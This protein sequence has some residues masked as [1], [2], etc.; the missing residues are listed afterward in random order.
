EGVLILPAPS[1]R[2]GGIRM[3][4]SACVRLLLVLALW[5]VPAQPQLLKL[6]SAD[7][8]KGDTG[9]VPHWDP[10]Q[11]RLLA[12]RDTSDSALATA[13]VFDSSGNS[14]PLFL[15][16][17][18]P[19]AKSLHVWAAAASPDG[20][21]ILSVLQRVSKIPPQR[22][23]EASEVEE[24]VVGGD[25]MLMTN[26]QSA[27]L[28]EPGVGS[29]HDPSPPVATKFTSVFVSPFL[30]VA[31]VRCDQFNAALAQSLAQ[32]IGI[33]SAVGNHA[34]RPWR[35][36]PFGRGTRTFASVSSASVTS[37]GEA[38]S[39][40]TPSGTPSP[41]ASTIHFVPLPRLVLPTASPLFSPGQNCRRERSRPIAAIP[42]GP[43]RPAKPATHPAIRL[44]LATVA[45]AASRS[46]AKETRRAETATP[47]R[48]AKPTECLQNRPGSRLAAVHACPFAV[49]A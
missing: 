17:D 8:R 24:S 6:D 29:L 49:S 44:A 19:G 30:V 23:P 36:R 13:R 43:V 42:P 3:K 28:A 10:V 45:I 25:Q 41:S 39:S 20:G 15:L 31:P 4:R 32:R 12:Y 21:A 37:A 9:Y 34:F 35:G 5:S 47:R 40:R 38:L 22:D 33:V 46:R 18:F 16:R 48:F 2:M 26:Q 14:V 11:D 7:D 27:E 1:W